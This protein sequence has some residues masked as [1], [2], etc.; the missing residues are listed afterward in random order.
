LVFANSGFD[1]IRVH[2][3]GRCPLKFRRD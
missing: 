1:Q 2:V 3:P